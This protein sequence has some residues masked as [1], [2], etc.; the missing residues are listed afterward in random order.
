MITIKQT[1][2]TYKITERRENT[3]EKR[4]LLAEYL[5]HKN[6][7]AVDV[8]FLVSCQVYVAP[9]LRRNVCHRPTTAGTSTYLK[10]VLL[11]PRQTEIR[12]LVTIAIA[13]GDV[14]TCQH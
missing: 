4:S 8:E 13:K 7:E 9:V 6:A 10:R 2:K 14:I 5:P 1:N 12:Y 11:P 3:V